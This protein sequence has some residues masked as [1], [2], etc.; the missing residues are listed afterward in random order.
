MYMGG[1]VSE[2]K[3]TNNFKNL[4]SGGYEVHYEHNR[5]LHTNIPVASKNK[6]TSIF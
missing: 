5:R 1:A 3:T 2:W 6:Y 4:F